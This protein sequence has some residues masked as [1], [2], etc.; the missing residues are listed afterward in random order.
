M[1]IVDR[2]ERPDAPA[3]STSPEGTVWQQF[4]LPADPHPL[5]RHT[6]HDPRS[7]DWDAKGLLPPFALDNA[8][9]ATLPTQDRVWPRHC[10]PW[11]QG[12][13]SCCTTNAALGLLMCEPFWAKAVVRAQGTYWK[14]VT[15]RVVNGVWQFL[16]LDCVELYKYETQID[17]SEIPGSYPPNDTGSTGLWSMKT[18]QAYKLVDNYYHAFDLPTALSLLANNGPVAV[19]SAWYDSMYYPDSDGIISISPDAQV[20]GAHEYAVRGVYPTERLVQLTNSWGG[21]WGLGGDV[22]MTWD[23]LARLLSED[24]DVVIPTI[25]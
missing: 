7:R 12:A 21:Q 5:G 16:E 1:P 20:V 19:G 24:G 22:Y 3:P 9:A 6:L 23:T 2:P 17:N 18:L 25:S 13:I 8:G 14:G 15:G 11:D 4:A 10:G